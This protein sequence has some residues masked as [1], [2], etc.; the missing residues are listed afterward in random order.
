MNLPLSPLFASSLRIP[1]SLFYPGIILICIIGAYSL[2]NNVFDVWAMLVF[3]I[4]GYLM[5]KYDIPGAPLVIAL[6][7]G[8]LLEQSLYRALALA[9]GDITVFITRPISATLLTIG[10]A[11]VVAV[12]F[13]SLRILR[14]Q[15]V[16]EEK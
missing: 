10:A 13:K 11:M 16:E 8:P 3:G 14:K 15:I 12:V 2:H 6:V 5:K 9:H 4:I 1:Y 7:L